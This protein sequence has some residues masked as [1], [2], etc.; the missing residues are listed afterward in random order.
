[1]YSVHLKPVYSAPAE[2]VPNGV[3]LPDDWSLSWHQ[4]ETLK[5][6]RDPSKERQLVLDFARYFVVDVFENAFA[7]DRARLA[8]RQINLIRDTCEFLYRLEQDKENQEHSEAKNSKSTV[9]EEE[10]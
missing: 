9:S 1:M 5:A 7:G 3:Q 8:G 4:L 2:Q 6:L 10:S